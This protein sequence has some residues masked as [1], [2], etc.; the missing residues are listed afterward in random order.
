MEKLISK[1]IELNKN[2]T[3]SKNEWR[4]YTETIVNSLKKYEKESNIFSIDDLEDCIRLTINT[5][6]TTNSIRYDFYKNNV[7]I[8]LCEGYVGEK[9]YEYGS[10]SLDVFVK[11]NLAEINENIL[12]VLYHIISKPYNESRASQYE[13]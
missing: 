1:M 2:W 12:D 11:L 4:K 13:F 8:Y 5:A 9:I 3:N 6:F 10:Y 7:K